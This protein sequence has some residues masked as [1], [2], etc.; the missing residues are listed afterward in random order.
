MTLT[1]SEREQ[2]QRL[3]GRLTD[4]EKKINR[5]QSIVIGIAIGVGIGG[6]IFGF[7]SI[8]E[9]IGVVK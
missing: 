6:A 4:I 9:L 7:I 2:I 8:K 5:I 3:D 1:K